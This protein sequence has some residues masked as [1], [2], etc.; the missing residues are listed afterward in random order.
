[1]EYNSQL[2]NTADTSIFDLVQVFG[3]FRIALVAQMTHRQ[4][5]LNRM[6]RWCNSLRRKHRT[7]AGHF[8]EEI[9]PRE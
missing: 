8:S 1:M 9:V 4:T 5:L 6:C 7:H 2:P 3:K